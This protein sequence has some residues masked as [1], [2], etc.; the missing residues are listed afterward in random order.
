MLGGNQLFRY[1]FRTRQLVSGSKKLC[2]EANPTKDALKFSK[3]DEYVKNQQW[4]FS[5]FVNITALENWY[6]SGR[7]FQKN[8]EVYWE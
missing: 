4:S 8:N 1:D 7:A 6:H 5:E 2:I 3:C